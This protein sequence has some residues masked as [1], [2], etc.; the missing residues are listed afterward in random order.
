VLEVREHTAGLQQVEDLA[1]ERI[2]GARRRRRARKDDPSR[3][4]L[5]FYL[6]A[7]GGSRSGI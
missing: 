7:F 5:W 6:G 2:A 3:T 1:V 4:G